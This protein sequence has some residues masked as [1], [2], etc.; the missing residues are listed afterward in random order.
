ME[1]APE[2]FEPRPLGLRLLPGDNECILYMLHQGL[3]SRPR[4]THYIETGISFVQSFLVQKKLGGK[5]HAPLLSGRH[6]FQRTAECVVGAG[7]HFNE[8]DSP[9]VKNDQIDFAAPAAVITLDELISF[10]L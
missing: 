7:F 1:P 4:D 6:R 9:A 2:I 10:F 8:N 5:D 3:S